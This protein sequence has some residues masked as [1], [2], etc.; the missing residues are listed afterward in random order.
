MASSD[1]IT[2]LLKRWEAGEQGALEQLLPSVYT[3]LKKIAN[4]AVSEKKGDLSL[5]PTELVHELFFKLNGQRRVSF[6]NRVQ[7]FGLAANII[8]RILMD[9]FKGKYRKKRGG[10]LQ[11]M[12][13]DEGLTAAAAG[14]PPLLE[15]LDIAITQLETIAPRQAKVVELRY[16]AGLSVEE[17]SAVLDISAKTIDR[18]WRS[19]RVWLYRFL[20]NADDTLS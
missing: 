19:A 14:R 8:R 11:I 20:K 13:L 6:E 16:F 17:I 3:E 9:H 18:D 2:A 5:V 4:R 7:F 10:G 15:D 12:S 1:H